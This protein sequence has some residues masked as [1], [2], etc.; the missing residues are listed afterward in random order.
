M[1]PSTTDWMVRG[2]LGVAGEAALAVGGGLVGVVGGGGGA[3]CCGDGRIGI[4]EVG[5]GGIA[6]GGGWMGWMCWRGEG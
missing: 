4:G 6:L 3:F 5:G 2:G 1:S